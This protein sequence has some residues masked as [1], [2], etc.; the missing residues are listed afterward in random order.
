MP[1]GAGVG[2]GPGKLGVCGGEDGSAVGA[3]AGYAF[4]EDPMT[5]VAP[6][7][8]A[9]ALLTAAV[10]PVVAAIGAGG[11]VSCTGGGGPVIVAASCG[12]GSP[13]AGL[14]A[15]MSGITSAAIGR[16]KLRFTSIDFGWPSLCAAAPDDET[17]AG[18]A[19]TAASGAL[20]GGGDDSAIPGSVLTFGGAS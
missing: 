8:A 16:V 2:A 18:T 19:S 13:A 3:N 14:G 11:P 5:A 17:S 10:S 4:D 6:S 1:I 9:N 7:D 15:G 20:A 12:G